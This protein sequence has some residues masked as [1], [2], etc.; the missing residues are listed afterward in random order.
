[1]LVG[2]QLGVGPPETGWIV[3]DVIRTD[4]IML[5]SNRIVLD[6]VE[7]DRIG[8]DCNR[9][10][11]DRIVIIFEVEFPHSAFHMGIEP[12]ERKRGRPLTPEGVPCEWICVGRRR[13][14]TGESGDFFEL[15]YVWDGADDTGI[16][17]S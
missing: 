4:H 5:E 2:V 10:G 15:R 6:Q 7:L 1:V 14:G 17:I 12:L 13:T 16:Q 3:L 9:I 8:S 11:S